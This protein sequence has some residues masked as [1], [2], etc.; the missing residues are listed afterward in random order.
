MRTYCTKDSSCVGSRTL[1]YTAGVCEYPLP[2]VAAYMYTSDIKQLS[3]DKLNAEG[4]RDSASWLMR[5]N[6]HRLFF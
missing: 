4:G 3:N 1:E 5:G 6:S 2:T